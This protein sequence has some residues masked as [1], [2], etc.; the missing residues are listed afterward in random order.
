MSRTDEKDLRL[1]KKRYR[2]ASRKERSAI[3]V[4]FLR[5]PAT[6]A[7]TRVDYSTVEGNAPRGPSSARSEPCTALRRP[8]RCSFCRSCS[9]TSIPRDCAKRSMPSCR[10]CT[11]RGS[12]KSAPDA[13]RSRSESVPP[14]WI[15][16]WLIGDAGR[17]SGGG[18]RSPAR[19]S[20]TRSR[21]AP[22]R[23]G[24]R[25]APD[26]VKWIWSI[27]AAGGSSAE[28]TTLGPYAS[29]MG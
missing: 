12:S 5:P 8:G 19:C 25:I 21:S 28:R 13:I 2:K 17:V 14:P 29:P 6:I 27:I 15:D 24:R 9:I 1:L 3:L 22:G 10:V 11:N 7:S 20:N 26:S 23:T 18:L 16:C 4:E